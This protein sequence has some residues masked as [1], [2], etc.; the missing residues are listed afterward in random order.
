[1]NQSWRLTAGLAL[2][3]LAAGGCGA[4]GS[5]TSRAA[6]STPAPSRAEWAAAT[7]R[8]CS[9]KRAAIARLGDVHITYAG[10]ARVGLPAVKR[11]L[12]G[13]LGRLRGV[14]REFSQRQRPV[15]TASSVASTMKIVNS[16]DAHSQAVTS[17]LSGDVARASSARQLSA[18]F[19]QWL[20]AL[21]RLASRGDALARQLKL[22][23]C[24]SGS[25]ARP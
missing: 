12:D 10:I 1:M 23:G 4:S 2:L 21:R 8:L 25:A 17:R 16:V 18:A 15:A 5:S 14:L 19:G 11:S 6:K 20:V 3:A 7:E 13:Y 9:E 22:T 24:T